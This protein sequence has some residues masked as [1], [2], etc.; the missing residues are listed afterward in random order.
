M[1]EMFGRD[2][3]RKGREGYV[4]VEASV[5]LPLSSILIL[6]L[7]YL[8]SYLYQGCFMVQAAYVSAFRGSRQEENR[9]EYV[10][11]QLDELLGMEVLSFGD[12]DRRVDAGG[13]FVKVTLEKDTPFS[14]LGEWILGLS[15]SFRVTVRNPVAYIRG[16]RS[17]G[18]PGQG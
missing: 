2:A 8:C 7:V 16:L 4:V 5:L 13:L 1:K 12:E 3:C 11:A 15:A 17:L 6:L 10:E 14:R 18:Q 9:T